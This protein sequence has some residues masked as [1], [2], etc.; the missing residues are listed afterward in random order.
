MGHLDGRQLAVAEAELEA[1]EAQLEIA[2]KAAQAASTR[3]E[4]AVAASGIDHATLEETEQAD[5]DLSVNE[6]ERFDA[7]HSHDKFESHGSKNAGALP[8]KVVSRDRWLAAR[9]TEERAR[10]AHKK[11][12]DVGRISARDAKLEAAEV[13]VPA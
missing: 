1:A 3:Y 6:A 5:F 11:A 12:R 2:M 13:S 9:S 8:D 10:E 7:E 4:Q